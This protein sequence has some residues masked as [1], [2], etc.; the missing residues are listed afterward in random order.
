MDVVASVDGVQALQ[1]IE[2]AL[3]RIADVLERREVAERGDHVVEVGSFVLS[4]SSKGDDCV[5]LYATHPGLKYYVAKVYVEKFGELPFEPRSATRR[6]SGEQA[7]SRDFAMR[8]GL[9]M[10]CPVFTAVLQPTGQLTDK[11]DL[12]RRFHRVL[13]VEDA[14]APAAPAPAAPAPAAIPFAM[15]TDGAA[16]WAATVYPA[17]YGNVLAAKT[18]FQ[19]YLR[20]SGKH[21]EDAA[22]GW[23]HLCADRD[24]GI[25]W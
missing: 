7:P 6:F 4:Q 3:A 15:T 16:T 10:P 19:Q 13:S 11:G 24:A 22:R 25:P 9:M 20:D 17:L 18:A 23:M 1:G 5:Y 2:R 21:G 12:V 14:P 8:E